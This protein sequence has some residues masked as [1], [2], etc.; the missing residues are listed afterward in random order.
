MLS[1]D[2]AWN[3]EQKAVCKHAIY[4]PE[5]ADEQFKAAFD[6]ITSKLIKE[7]SS[8]LRGGYYLDAVRD[9]GN[10]SHTLFMAQLWYIPLTSDFTAQDLHDAFTDVFYYSFLD[11]D[12][13]LTFSI[14]QKG[15]AAAAKLA[16]IVTPACK[17]VLDHGFNPRQMVQDVLGL[18][19][20]HTFLHDYG[21]SLIKRIAATGKDAAY[22]SNTIVATAAAGAPLP[23]QGVSNT[24]SPDLHFLFT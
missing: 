6:G 3:A 16:E 10:L 23:A 21:A 8:K 13:S 1:G 5:N 2:K 18:G 17:A 20:R 19:A 12:P 4:S 22:I 9:V 7:H 15:R 24:V 14:R 11:L